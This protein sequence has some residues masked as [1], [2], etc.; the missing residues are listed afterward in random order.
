MYAYTHTHTHEC[1]VVSDAV[2]IKRLESERDFFK[3]KTEEAEALKKELDEVKKVQERE[4]L[5]VREYAYVC[6]TEEKQEREPPKVR[7]HARYVY[8]CMC[9]EV[10]VC[11]CVCV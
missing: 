5:K 11:V 4:A 10:Y 9:V 1:S 7:E 6:R 3:Q 8:M 2:K